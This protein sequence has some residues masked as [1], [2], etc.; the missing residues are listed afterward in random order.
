MS[1]NDAGHQSLAALHERRKQV[2]RLHKR[3]FG[4]MQIV[5]LTGLPSAPLSIFT[6]LAVLRPSSRKTGARKTGK[7][8]NFRL[9]KR[10]TF[11]N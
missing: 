6:R 3:K 7:A 2:I 1:D 8:G 11:K 9:L 5:E 4:V 10:L